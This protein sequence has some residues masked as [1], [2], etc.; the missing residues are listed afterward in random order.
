MGRAFS[1]PT[2]APATSRL[3]QPVKSQAIM[4]PPAIAQVVTD[5]AMR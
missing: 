4:T 2:I 3:E 1:H 5:E